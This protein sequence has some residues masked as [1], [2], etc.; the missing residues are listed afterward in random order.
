[1]S[2]MT[3]EEFEAELGA[4]GP[5]A[6]GSTAEEMSA[7]TGMSVDRVR[8]LLKQAKAA[9]RLEVGTRPSE[10]LDGRRLRTNVYR[11]LPPPAAKKKKRG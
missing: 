4:A 8:Q 11:I 6:E 2:R 1:M 9:G 5:A 7:A 10:G 3:I